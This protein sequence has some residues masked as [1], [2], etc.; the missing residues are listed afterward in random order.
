[1]EY[2]GKILDEQSLAS[3]AKQGDREAFDALVEHFS[4]RLRSFLAKRMANR[5][6]VEDVVQETFLKAYLNIKSYNE[7]YKFACWLFTIAS[8]TS[9]NLARTKRAVYF[10]SLEDI[11]AAAAEPFMI[12]GENEQKANMWAAAR[13][14]EAKQ[15]SAI[16]LKYSQDLTVKEI[17][18][19]LGTTSINVRVLLHRA[20][21]ELIKKMAKAKD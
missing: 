18:E 17:A 2:D 7:K 1:M 6:D 4:P 15:Y 14:L 12:A 11:E 10:E 5:S 21:N 13:T 16:Y 9:I 3:M 8:R 19:V 20:R